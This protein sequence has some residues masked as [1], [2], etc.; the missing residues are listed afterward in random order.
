MTSKRLTR[1]LAIAVAGSALAAAPA[2][3]FLRNL[4]VGSASSA[5]SSSTEKSG[6]VP[7][8]GQGQ[9][10]RPLGG[11]VFVSPQLSNLAVNS[12]GPAGLIPPLVAGAVE[13]DSLGASWR[14]FGR[15]F[16]VTETPTPPPAGGAASYV[17]AVQIVR[18]QSGSSS[19]ATRTT[20]ATCPAGKLVVAGGAELDTGSPDVGLVSL[21]RVQAGRGWRVV[22]REVDETGTQWRLRVSAVCAN[23]TTETATA[24]YTANPTTN[25]GSTPANSLG[26]KSRT[27][28]CG[29]GR[30]VV[31]GGARVLGPGGAPAPSDVAITMSAPAGS[32]PTATGWQ[33]QA[34]ETDTTGSSWRLLVQVVCANLNAGPPA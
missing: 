3:A 27:E 16:C 4:T 28:T 11:A 30:S 25:S 29:G 17:K 18:A 24:N 7:C 1:A 21:Q 33:A 32:G 31:G 15:V 6:A 26:T 20:V 12:V 10:T 13:T 34:R 8:P 9:L 2:G 22:A 23:A 14:L 19:D 5:L